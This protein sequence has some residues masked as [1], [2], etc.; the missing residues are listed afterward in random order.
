MLNIWLLLVAVVV[1]VVIQDMLV[2]VA[3]LED[4]GLALH[5]L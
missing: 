4:L 5:F 3:V 1:V 2:G